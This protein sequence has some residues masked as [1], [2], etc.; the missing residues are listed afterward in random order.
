MIAIVDPVLLKYAIQTPYYGTV[1][2]QSTAPYLH[3]AFHWFLQIQS[4]G[5]RSFHNLAAILHDMADWCWC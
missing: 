5:S 3:V 4:S 2:M 1:Y